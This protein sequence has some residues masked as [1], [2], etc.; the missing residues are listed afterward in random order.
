M[1]VRAPEP[2]SFIRGYL[3]ALPFASDIPPDD[4]ESMAGEVVA[5]LSPYIQ[6]GELEAP[7]CAWTVIA[8]RPT[9]A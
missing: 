4:M 3:R 7:S 8:A 9:Q 2:L 1:R 6:A 5:R